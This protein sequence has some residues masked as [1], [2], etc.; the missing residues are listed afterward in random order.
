[1]A[2]TAE[3]PFGPGPFAPMAASSLVHVST[4]ISLVLPCPAG[5]WPTARPRERALADPISPVRRVL[6]AIGRDGLLET[7][8]HREQLRLG[9]D[10]F[11]A[12]FHVVLQ[13]V[14]QHDRIDRAAFLAE[15]AIDALEQ[16]DVIARGAALAV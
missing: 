9:D 2:A 13:D 3:Q 7:V 6:R 16:V 8:A 12:A 5:K 11:A 1:M 10:V 15:A 4:Y 14:G